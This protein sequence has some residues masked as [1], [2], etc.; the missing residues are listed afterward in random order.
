MDERMED[1]LSIIEEA[2]LTG[3]RNC[4]ARRLPMDWPDSPN[5][6]MAIKRSG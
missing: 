4:T 6:E 2:G 3:V 5:S 1:I